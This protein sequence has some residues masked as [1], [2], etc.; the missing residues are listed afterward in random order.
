MA[1]AASRQGNKNEARLINQARTQ[2]L[3]SMDTASPEYAQARQVYSGNPEALQMRQGIGGLADID[4]M[5]AKSVDRALFGGT[6]QNAEL[7]AQALGDKA[8]T[9][10]AARIYNAMDAARGDPV[11]FAS[12][13][14]PDKRTTDMLRTYAGGNQLD[15]TL[16]VINQAKLGDRMRFGSPTQPRIQAEQGLQDVAGGALNT[17][18][19]FKT[20]GMTA[21][22]R[23]AANMLG[24]G[25]EST[26][27]QF[28]KDM[29]DLMLTDQGM[30]L[31]RRVASG[32]QTA[33]QELQQV[34]L[35][36]LV[37]GGSARATTSMPFTT[38]AIGGLTTPNAQ[39]NNFIPQNKTMPQL[40]EGFIIQQQRFQELPEGFIIQ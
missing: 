6:Q 1:E 38:A 16:N 21:I 39:Q 4:P 25:N 23:K 31:M 36:S 29:A 13:I 37:A 26:D 8:P 7:T 34:G 3:E 40:P 12:K 32:Q 22:V 2:L 10:A 17:A 11:T 27:P 33:I 24:R 14:A 18:V 5:D 35:P 9:A 19:D 28:Y 20:G 30:D 15:E